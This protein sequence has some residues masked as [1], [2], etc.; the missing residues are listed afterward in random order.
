MKS[1]RSSSIELARSP[2]GIVSDNQGWFGLLVDQFL[3][4]TAVG[5]DINARDD[6]VVGH[7]FGRYEASSASWPRGR[8]ARSACPIPKSS[9][10]IL[11]A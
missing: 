2:A 9:T 3:N 11:P 4:F 10:K 6:F 5:R 7:N 1:M 8:R